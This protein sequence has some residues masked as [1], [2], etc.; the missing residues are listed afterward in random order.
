MSSLQ[1]HTHSIMHQQI[2]SLSCAQVAG[3][4]QSVARLEQQALEL[5]SKLQEAQQQLKQKVC[6]ARLNAMC[7]CLA[8][9]A[10]SVQESYVIMAMAW[11]QLLSQPLLCCILPLRWTKPSVRIARPA[12]PAPVPQVAQLAQVSAAAA[13]QQGTS[14]THAEH[15]TQ[16][17]RQEEASVQQLQAALKAA[18]VATAQLCT[19]GHRHQEFIRTHAP[20]AFVGVC[21]PMHHF[22]WSH[23]Q[24][25][26]LLP[27]L[28]PCSI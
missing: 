16:R 8:H 9:A 1:R 12:Q 11:H 2:E 13:E 27:S 15:L 6:G 10:V 14:A 24:P 22:V 21:E 26:S 3:L 28:P 7:C 5:H 19:K 18:G 25:S 20:A 17:L 23:G 4:E